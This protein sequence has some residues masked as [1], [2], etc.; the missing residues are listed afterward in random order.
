[1]ALTLLEAAKLNPGDVLMNTIVEAFVRDVD[2]MRVLP[3]K[4][5]KGNA[6]KFN[7]EGTL[8]T[9]GFRA[10]NDSYTEATGIL[11]PNTEALF[12]GGGDIDVDKFIVKTQGPEQR[13]AQEVMKAKSLSHRISYTFVKGDSASDSTVPDGLQKRCTGTQLVAQGSTSGG[14]VLTLSKLDE[15]IDAVDNPTHLLMSKAMRRI[16]TSAARLY[17]VGGFITYDVDAFGRKI[18]KY[19]DLPIIIADQNGNNNAALAFDEA[20]PAAGGTACTSIYVL[21]LGD[22]QLCGIQAAPMFVVDL[23]ELQTKPV[24]R[25][26]IEWY[27]GLAAIGPRSVARLWGIKTGAAAA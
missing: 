23:G 7:R 5:I 1:M 8:P 25:T 3:F 24:F 18:A 4:T 21:S 14:D 12:I 11:D 16:L 19:N 17:T 9:T 15:V 22:D 13:S 27:V 26:R 2:L 20:D 10:V 6:L